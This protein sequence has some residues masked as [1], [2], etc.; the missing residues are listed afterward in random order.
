MQSKHISIRITEIL[1][2][3]TILVSIFLLNIGTP[4]PVVQAADDNPGYP[5]FLPMISSGAANEGNPPPPPLTC[6]QIANVSSW[7]GEITVSYSIAADSSSQQISEMTSTS[8]SGHLVETYRNPS[9]I[10]FMATTPAG[11]GKI[12]SS[13][14]QIYPTETD[15]V[16]E[17]KGDGPPLPYDPL[18]AD[19]SRI[20]LA[21]NLEECTYTLYV[22]VWI[23]GTLTIQDHAPSPINIGIIHAGSADYSIPDNSQ[24]AITGSGSWPAHSSDYVMTQMT[25]IDFYTQDDYDIQT[26]LGEDNMGAAQVSWSFTPATGP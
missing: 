2:R 25:K 5:V 4:R 3:L 9:A 16:E 11:N 23:Q 12:D 26:I 24:M 20:M 15:L 18:A 6:Q 14:I 22:G 21:F 8:I 17:L 19:G 13:K 7:N 1:G 10:G